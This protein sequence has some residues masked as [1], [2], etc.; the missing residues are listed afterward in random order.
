MFSFVVNG[1]VG[2]LLAFIYLVMRQAYT[3]T[4][5]ASV[6]TTFETSGLAKFTVPCYFILNGMAAAVVVH[7]ARYGL[8]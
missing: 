4:Y 1:R 8:S 2:G 5:R 3:S 6:G 7:M